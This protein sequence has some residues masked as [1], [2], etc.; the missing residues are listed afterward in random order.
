MKVKILENSQHGSKEYKIQYGYGIAAGFIALISGEISQISRGYFPKLFPLEYFLIS[1]IVIAI[2]IFA[3]LFLSKRYLIPG[4]VLMSISFVMSVIN[5][6]TFLVL[7]FW[8]L[9]FITLAWINLLFVS[10]FLLIGISIGNLAK[11]W[12]LDRST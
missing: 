2:L 10:N 12:K 5:D 1:Y 6:L 7:N 8:K 9:W 11:V 3:S 4:L